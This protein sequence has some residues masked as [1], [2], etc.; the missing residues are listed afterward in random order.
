[1]MVIGDG[2]FDKVLRTFVHVQRECVVRL[3]ANVSVDP[4]NDTLGHDMLANALQVVLRYVLQI[5]EGVQTHSLALVNVR[6]ALSLA[7][8]VPM[9]MPRGSQAGHGHAHQVHVVLFARQF[10]NVQTMSEDGFFA[11]PSKTVVLCAFAAF[12]EFLL[13]LSGGRF[14]F[15]G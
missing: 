14:E 5:Q 2:L 3:L 11:E 15:R 8:F 9:R 6:G 10:G 7:L 12:G 13:D 4:G 1:M